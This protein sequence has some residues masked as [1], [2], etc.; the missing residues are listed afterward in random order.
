MKIVGCDLHARQQTLAIMDTGTGEFT[1]K[2]LLHDENTVREF[3]AG[4]ESPVAGGHRSHRSDAVVSGTAGRVGHR[5]SGRHP[6]KIRA[7]ETRRQKHD[8]RD[9]GLLLM[10]LRED[11]FPE[12]WMPSS[13]QRDLRTL[14][15]DRDQWV[16]VRSRVQHTLQGIALNHGLR[17]GRSLWKRQGQ[18]ALQALPLPPYTAQRR[19]ELLDMYEQL[20]K[21]TQEL[22]KE[23]ESQAR[24][25]PQARR[26]M[27]HPG[28]GR[29]RT[30]P[31][32]KQT[33][34]ENCCSG[35][36]ARDTARTSVSPSRENTKPN[37]LTSPTVV[38]DVVTS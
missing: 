24:Q 13:E 34:E 5:V 27:T 30:M 14:L 29:A 18:S 9:A 19:N 23:V 12:I 17:Q 37:S 35:I 26:L 31:L 4:L 36:S 10:L 33:I 15:R 1:E 3:Y 32:D 25:R 28:V 38:R 6:A 16:R 7:Q 2:T 20:Q 8:R 21:R 11:R 22:D